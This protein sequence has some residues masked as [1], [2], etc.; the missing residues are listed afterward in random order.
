MGLLAM[1]CKLC[2]ATTALVRR[3]PVIPRWMYDLLPNDGRNFRII[4]GVGNEHEQRSQSGLYDTFACSNCEDRFQKLDDY[5][6]KVL[7]KT[8]QVTASGFDFRSYDYGKLARFYLSILWRMHA[9][10]L[11]IAT[12]DLGAASA[13]LAQALLGGDEAVLDGYE[14]IP[15][16]SR[17]ILSMGIMGPRWVEY[18]AVRYWKLYMP[19]FQILINITGQ[20]GSPRFK[21]WLMRAGIPLRMLED[22]FESG[23]AE[24]AAHAIRVNMERKDAR[25]N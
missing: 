18:D 10:C 12:I 11:P 21:S 20:P 14:I 9:C 5:A 7:R 23:E 22:T 4:S 19:R 17:H 13:P 25:R 16:C 6:A 24:I 2:G 15:T 1:T 3:S 8:P